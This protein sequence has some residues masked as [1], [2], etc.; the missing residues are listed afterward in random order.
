[1]KTNIKALQLVEKGLSSKTISNLTESQIDILHKKM[2]GE[3][4]VTNTKIANAIKGLDV[5]KL[6]QVKLKLHQTEK[7][8]E[9]F[10]LCEWTRSKL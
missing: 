9:L 1:M 7:Y 5:L 10:N 8:Y 3:Q 4:P 6:N 2:I